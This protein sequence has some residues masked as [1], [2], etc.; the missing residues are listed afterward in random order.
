MVSFWNKLYAVGIVP[1][2]RVSFRRQRLLDSLL[3]QRSLETKAPDASG[4]GRVQPLPLIMPAVDRGRRTGATVACRVASFE[5]REKR[6]SGERGTGNRI[7]HVTPNASPPR[8]R[9]VPYPSPAAMSHPIPPMGVR[10]G[11]LGVVGPLVVE[12]PFG[13]GEPPT[14]LRGA[15]ADPSDSDHPGTPVPGGADA[16]P[17]CGAR[18]AGLCAGPVGGAA[19]DG[20]EPDR[21]CACP[22]SGA[23]RLSTTATKI[24]TTIEWE[25]VD[26]TLVKI[27]I[28]REKCCAKSVVRNA[29]EN[30]RST[31]APFDRT[32]EPCGPPATATRLAAGYRTTVTRFVVV[33]F[34]PSTRTKYTP[35]ESELASSRRDV[36]S[37]PGSV[38]RCTVATR[39]PRTL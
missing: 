6:G 4:S 16:P 10:S 39:C 28:G 12:E 36:V 31:T 32:A 30:K 33:K 3:R 27:C 15:P 7:P 37:S 18:W 26:P 17:P 11:L 24:L 21:D 13:P 29:S 20:A 38:P 9:Y 35:D 34:S 22:R 8:S 25:S 23:P 19:C 1:K 14:E 2:D 5:A